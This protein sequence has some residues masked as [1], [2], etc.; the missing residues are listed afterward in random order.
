MALLG[1]VP[2]A[3]AI[4]YLKHGGCDVNLI[5]KD[6]KKAQ[7][8]AFEINALHLLEFLGQIKNKNLPFVS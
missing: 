4:R 1:S 8:I 2:L 3:R 5:S 6:L 7:N